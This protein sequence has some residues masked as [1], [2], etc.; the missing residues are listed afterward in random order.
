MA[1]M[2]AIGIR[3][4][5]A[6]KMVLESLQLSKPKAT[7]RDILV[8]I[9]AV[10]VNPVDTKVRGGAGNYSAKLEEPKV[11]G[12]DGSG[13]VD[14]VG[15]EAKKFKVGDQVY[16]AGSVIRNGTNSEYTL[17]DE[18]IVGRKPKSL[19]HADAAAL[20]L[21]ALT[22]WELLLEQMRIQKGDPGT[23]LIINAA[24]GVGSIAIQLARNVLDL[25]TVIATASRK[26]TIEW[27]KQLG[28]THVIDHHKDLKTQ[29]DQ[30][31][32]SVDY[33]VIFHDPDTYIPK[34]LQIIKPYGTI[35]T[36]LDPKAANFVGANLKCLTYV[37]EFMFGKSM[38]G[39]R[40]ESQGEILDTIAEGIDAGTLRPI[41]QEK[42]DLSVSHLA[43]IHERVESG[44]VF[45]KAVLRV[46]EGS[47]SGSG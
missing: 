5:G 42:M 26:E 33:V 36:I 7:G 23:L 45:G 13:I 18:R 31:G 40:M 46:V 25:K 3:Q 19:D 43:E 12:Y 9:Q 15:S 11:L 37:H 39:I 17:V 6:A 38:Y 10:S 22:A 1:T 24:G 2:N 21:V 8:K 44:K 16:F 34:A 30:L 29:I 47:F 4:K 41:T 14:S 20:P 28:A 27:V 35:G 32:L